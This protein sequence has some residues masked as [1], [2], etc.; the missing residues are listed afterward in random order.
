MLKSLSIFYLLNVFYFIHFPM[1]A[2]DAQV[3]T[4]QEILHDIIVQKIIGDMDHLSISPKRIQIELRAVNDAGKW[5]AAQL[6]NAFLKKNIIIFQNATNSIDTTFT[7]VLNK[8]ET[9]IKYEGKNKGVFLNYKSYEREI[10][11]NIDFYYTNVDKSISHS[12]TGELMNVDIIAGTDIESVENSILPFTL[13]VREEQKFLKRI[14][15]PAI[16]TVVTIGVVYLFF[17]LRSGS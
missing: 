2:G 17:S 1:Y 16:V 11:A 14:L 4:N 7:I 5:V 9:Q 13:G 3:K 8:I 12:F 15:E 10:K 6:R